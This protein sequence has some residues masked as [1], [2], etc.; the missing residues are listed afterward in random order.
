MDRRTQGEIISKPMSK[1]ETPKA[2]KR[3]QS[4]SEDFRDSQST[5]DLVFAKLAVIEK[6]RETM[7][8]NTS[9]LG[10]V[11]YAVRDKLDAIDN[12]KVIDRLDP[13]ALLMLIKKVS[14]ESLSFVHA[15]VRVTEEWQQQLNSFHQE[16]SATLLQKNSGTKA[17]DQSNGSSLNVKTIYSSPEKPINWLSS[18]K[19]QITT[20]HESLQTQNLHNVSSQNSKIAK[21]EAKLS[22]LSSSLGTLAHTY[23]THISTVC[24]TQTS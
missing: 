19:S 1:P 4:L 3:K 13:R 18:T 8:H 16:Y 10:E 22:N 20:L 15:S 17:I 23:T 24:M 2:V 7:S 11:M 12:D 6:L 9:N 5:D 21:L 14:S